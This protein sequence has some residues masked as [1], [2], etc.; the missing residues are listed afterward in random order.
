MKVPRIRTNYVKKLRK[1]L[2]KKD[3]CSRCP[4]AFRFWWNKKA[5]CKTCLSFI[6]LSYKWNSPHLLPDK[7]HYLH[8][9]PCHR[10]GSKEA[11]TRACSAILEWDLGRHKWQTEE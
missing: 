10:L 11:L 3:P 6:G 5:K 7:W 4:Y 2:L 9:C 8:P 1:M